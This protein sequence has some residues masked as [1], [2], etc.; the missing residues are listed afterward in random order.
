MND[1]VVQPFAER[2]SNR[3][4]Y[5]IDWQNIISV[6]LPMILECFKGPEQ[7]AAAAAGLT[8]M[9]R[10]GL[11]LRCRREIARLESAG[12]LRFRIGQRA[13]AINDLASAI[14]AE[15]TATANSAV[16]QGDIFAAAFDEAA[17]LGGQ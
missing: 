10:F 14:E 5:G 6:I 11:Q 8:P 12:K 7:L 1:S 3:T 4:R 13:A 16:M 9:Q 15:L 2:V 17:Q